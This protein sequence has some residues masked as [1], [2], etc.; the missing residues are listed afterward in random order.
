[1]PEDLP[2][3]TQF[4]GDDCKTQVQI[5]LQY[6]VK[7]STNAVLFGSPR[8]SPPPPPPIPTSFLL[9]LETGCCYISQASLERMVRAVGIVAFI[10][11]PSLQN[12]TWCNYH[13]AWYNSGQPCW[14][15]FLAIPYSWPEPTDQF[16]TFL[17]MLEGREVGTGVGTVRRTNQW[18]VKYWKPVW[19]FGWWCWD[20]RSFFY[21]HYSSGNQNLVCLCGLVCLGVVIYGSIDGVAA[22]YVWRDWLTSKNLPAYKYKKR[23]K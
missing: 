9:A 18:V 12:I 15:Q 8:L 22:W 21:Y 17:L 23:L 20:L 19:R 14:S 10:T 7:G 3:V 6:P 5:P 13:K 2:F 4:A 16:W 11:M 1:M